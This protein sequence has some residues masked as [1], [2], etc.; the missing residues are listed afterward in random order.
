MDRQFAAGAMSF[1]L[2]RRFSI[3]SFLCVFAVAG[4]LGQVLARMVS[5]RL[6]HRDAVVTMELVQSVVRADATAPYFPQAQGGT[7]PQPLEETLKQ[8]ASMLRANVYTP[9]RVPASF[10]ENGLD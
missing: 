1:N 3:L 2:T 10:P 5:Q 8:I 7:L 4:I 9:E 6:L